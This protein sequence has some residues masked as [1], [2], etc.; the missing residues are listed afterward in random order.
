MTGW[1]RGQSVRREGKRS[2]G[3]GRSQAVAFYSEC[4]AS[5]RRDRVKNTESV[6]N[7]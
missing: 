2:G 4:V 3:G 1:T 5:R 6:L 7:I